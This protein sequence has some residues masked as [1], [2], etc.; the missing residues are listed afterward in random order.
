VSNVDDTLLVRRSRQGDQRAYAELVQRYRG[1]I[2]SVLLRMTRS[3]ADA[4]NLCQEAFL[5]AY[6]SLGSFEERS[7]YSTWLYRIA[8]NLALNH[9]E[10]HK[11]AVP[12]DAEVHEDMLRTEPLQEDLEQHDALER[13]RAAIDRLPPRQKATVL[14]RD[15]E[16]LSYAEV[17]EALE[18]P[19]GTAKAN[20]FHA[21]R[22]LRRHLVEPQA[23]PS[24]ERQPEQSSAP[25]QGVG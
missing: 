3:Q 5:K 8:V 17:A 12:W 14:L 22:N 1:R 11:R 20:H 2:H 15:Y 10:R 6:L 13:L 18:C 23:S 9:V 7:S 21:I 19:V 25:V 16:G 4:E 24:D